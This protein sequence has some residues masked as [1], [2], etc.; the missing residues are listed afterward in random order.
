MGVLAEKS[1]LGMTEVL[2]PDQDL[3]PIPVRTFGD[4]PL[5]AL[6]SRGHSSVAIVDLETLLSEAEH[7]T[8]LGALD[9]RAA[10]STSG[11]LNP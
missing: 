4:S 11:S 6:A 7:R 2:D 10:Q 8:V 1:T 3:H 5:Q 9:D